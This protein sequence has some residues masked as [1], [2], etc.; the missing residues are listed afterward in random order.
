MD[1]L[2]ANFFLGLS[3]H[4]GGPK[5]PYMS[6]TA[7]VGVSQR[8]NY[9]TPGVNLAVNFYNGGLGAL[10]NSSNF[11]ID[12]VLTPKLT[13]GGGRGNAMDIYPL[14][15]NSGTG[16]EDNFKYSA[17]LGTNFI[18]NNNNRNQQ[19]GF[20]QVR[21]FDFSFQTYNDFNGFKKIGISDG[22][23]RWFTGGGN[24]TFG[25]KNSDFQFIIASDVFTA[26][27]DVQPRS[28]QIID[29]KSVNSEEMLL[30]VY[31]T[32]ISS[33]KEGSFYN[34]Y[35]THKPNIASQLTQDYLNEYRN[36]VQWNNQM[37]D[38]S[39]NQGRTSFKLKTPQGN[40]GLN[41]LGSSHMW[42]QNAIHNK[43]NFHVIPS[44][45]PNYWEFQYTASPNS[46][47]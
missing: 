16:L 11:N 24:F 22:Y 18:V 42:S 46:P 29:G 41:G 8:F 38:F 25:S 1:E 33:P 14:T 12:A 10:P 36:G 19:V 43:I 40:F 21:A 34:R 27:T 23:D 17:T 47:F 35:F 20:L 37:H 39:L 32:N 31:D 3:I 5:K 13:V 4:F 26:D 2:E 6:G 30:D 15:L 45:V 9:V 44:T 28:T 7:G